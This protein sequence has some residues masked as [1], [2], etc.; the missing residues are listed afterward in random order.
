MT[1]LARRI[2][3]HLIL[4]KVKESDI[5]DRYYIGRHS[6]YEHM[7]GGSTFENPQYPNLDFWKGWYENQLKE[8]CSFIIEYYNKSIGVSKFHHISLEDNNATYAIGIFE[9]T[10]YSKGIGTEVTKHMIK[11]GFE[12]LKLHRID[13]K[14]LNYNTRAIKCYE[15]CGFK[16]DG[17]MRENAYIDGVYYSDVVMS[18]LES[19]FQKD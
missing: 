11:Y 12:E 19:E 4:R 15:K 17:I 8:E 14:V 10:Y 18:I 16:V 2:N 3:D 9:P 13:L 7:C 5:N 1:S 6:E